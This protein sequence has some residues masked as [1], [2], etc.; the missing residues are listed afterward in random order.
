MGILAVRAQITTSHLHECD[1]FPFTAIYREKG[2]WRL[3]FQ[4]MIRPAGNQE[5]E[6]ALGKGNSVTRWGRA[7]LLWQVFSIRHTSW[8][9]NSTLFAQGAYHPDQVRIFVSQVGVVD[10]FR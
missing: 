7:L 1:A 9:D 2:W 8:V 5:A 4:I 6:G 10:S 3:D